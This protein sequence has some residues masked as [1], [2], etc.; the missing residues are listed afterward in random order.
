MKPDRLLCCMFLFA[1]LALRIW[2]VLEQLTNRNVFV[3]IFNCGV[4]VKTKD[5]P[6]SRTFQHTLQHHCFHGKVS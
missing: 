2:N 4:N 6:G 5:C 1:F 3:K